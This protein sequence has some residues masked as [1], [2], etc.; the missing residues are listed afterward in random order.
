MDII[1]DNAQ[2]IIRK[3]GDKIICIEPIVK[4]NAKGKS[5]IEYLI[6]EYTLSKSYKVNGSKK[7]GK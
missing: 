6:N 3:E 7:R 1:S 2:T 5:I 4:L